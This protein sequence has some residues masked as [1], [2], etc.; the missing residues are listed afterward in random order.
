MLIMGAGGREGRGREP[1]QA[2]IKSS[3]AHIMEALLLLA[4]AVQ[5][6]SRPATGFDS[7]NFP[8]ESFEGLPA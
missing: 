5:L 8:V 4:L 6:R 3:F 2:L 7:P 1:K